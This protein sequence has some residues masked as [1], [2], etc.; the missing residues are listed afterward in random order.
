MIDKQGQ[1]RQNDCDDLG[2]KGRLLRTTKID[3]DP[4]HVAQEAEWNLRIDEGE[5]WLKN[6]QLEAVVAEV[7]SIADDISQGP[8]GL[9]AHVQIAAAEQL[10]EERNGSGIDDGLRLFGR[11]RGD[12]RESPGSLELYIYAKNDC[13]RMK[14]KGRT[15]SGELRQ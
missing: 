4:G 1:S 6:A 12:V 15:H 2:S 13:V 14:Q 11:S 3:D 7:W 9:F 8:D 5:K 10:E